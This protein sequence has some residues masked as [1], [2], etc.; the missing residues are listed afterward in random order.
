[1]AFDLHLSGDLAAHRSALEALASS[2][3]CTLLWTAA[4]VSFGLPHDNDAV[5]RCFAGLVALSPTPTAGSCTTP[6]PASPSTSRPRG[7]GPQPGWIPP[8]VCRRRR[9]RWRRSGPPAHGQP[10]VCKN[11][12]CER[13]G[14]R[15]LFADDARL[16]V[17]LYGVRVVLHLGPGAAQACPGGA[18]GGI[19]SPP[20]A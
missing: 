6:R 14:G 11:F 7:A 20:P 4:G 13:L 5:H 1:M 17:D 3:G 18:G 19:S 12:W 9:G 2:T 8:T 15:V 16:E 10:R